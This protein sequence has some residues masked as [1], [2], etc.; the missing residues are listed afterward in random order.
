MCLKFV[1]QH[2]ISNR[3]RDG[4]VSS[5]A[6]DYGSRIDFGCAGS[7]STQIA[8]GVWRPDQLCGINVFDKVAADKRVLIKACLASVYDCIQEASDEIQKTIGRE[9]M[10]NYQPRDDVYGSILRHFLGAKLMR[11]EWITVQAKC[12][13]RGDRTDRHKDTKNCSWSCYDKTAAICFMLVDALGTVWS[14]KFISNGRLVIGSYFDK[15]LGVETLC[16]RIKSHF[17]KLDAAY[18]SF[19]DDYDGSYKPSEELCWKNPWAFFL[20]DRCKWME[21]KDRGMNDIVYRCIVLPTIVVRDFWLSAPLHIVIEMKFCF[22][23]DDKTL[24]ELILLGAYQTSWFRFFHIGTKMMGAKAMSQP[25]QTYIK[26]AEQTFGSITGGPKP[27]ADPPGINIKAVY[28]PNNFEMKRKVIESLMLLLSWVNECPS[29]S[30]NHDSICMK[31]LE[32]SRAILGIKA[33]AELGEF[34]LMLILQMCALS[35]V[36]L[37]PSP[38]LLH[39]LY[40][41]PGKGSANHLLDINVQEA[42]HQDA[43]KRVLHHF[44]L[45]EFGSNAGESILCETFPGRK[46]FDA[47]FP[48]QSL[49]LMNSK[50]IPMRKKYLSPT[51]KPLDDDSNTIF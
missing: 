38:K 36:V 14:L 28:Y 4:E 13:S 24:L 43:L 3:A 20:D 18:A 37:I 8:P 45:K 47:F 39:L 41:I 17:D 42:D 35:S 11:N 31:V 49:F 5:G 23:L 30:F 29:E 6:F 51:W 16:I 32:T 33:G 34:R 9:P 10:F 48:E 2:G 19:L 1:I 40:P 12:I 44:D 15:L 27:R 46:V 22:G 25:F 50:G 21:E 7:G 26:F